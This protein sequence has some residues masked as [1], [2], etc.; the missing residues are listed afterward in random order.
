M[1]VETDLGGARVPKLT[2]VNAYDPRVTDF[3]AL[4][5]DRGDQMMLGDFNTYHLYWFSRQEMT[6][7]TAREEALYGAINSWHPGNL[8]ELRHHH[9]VWKAG[10]L[11]SKA[12]LIVQFQCSG[13]QQI[14]Y[15][16]RPL[17]LSIMEALKTRPFQHGFKQRHF[18]TSALFSPYLALLGWLQANCFPPHP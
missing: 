1:A 7:A 11:M 17:L 6:M 13:Q 12:T 10:S 18:T 14:S 8:K 5:E 15:L 4:L 16:E 9:R 2:F 3:D